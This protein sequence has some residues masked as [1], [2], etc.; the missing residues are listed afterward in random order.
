MS[1]RFVRIMIFFDLPTLSLADG[2]NYRKF[3]KFL[4]KNGFIMTQYSVYTKLILNESQAASIKSLIVKNVPPK[5]LV[6]CLK[7]TEKQFA[8]IEYL[9]GKKKSNFVDNDSRWV[10]IEDEF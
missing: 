1:Y 8:D 10:E 3:H 4:I 6:Q 7:V 2:K 5:G 9:V